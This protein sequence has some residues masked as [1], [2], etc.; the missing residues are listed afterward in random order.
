MTAPD[1]QGRGWELAA[2][3]YACL[4]AL[5]VSCGKHAPSRPDRHCAWCR[6]EVACRDYRA[7]VEPGEASA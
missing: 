5:G 3:L 2:E 4:S 7:A 1:I 6:A